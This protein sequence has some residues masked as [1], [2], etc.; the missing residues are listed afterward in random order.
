MSDTKLSE[1]IALSDA[2]AGEA[3]GW[4]V[5]SRKAVRR[6]LEAKRIAS[7]LSS[8]DQGQLLP[9]HDIRSAPVRESLDALFQR[10][11]DLLSRTE[12]YLPKAEAMMAIVSHRMKAS[13]TSEN[14]S[15]ANEICSAVVSEVLIPRLRK[16]IKETLTS[17]QDNYVDAAY[18]KA[19]EN[20]VD[21][22]K[23][24]NQGDKPQE[25]DEKVVDAVEKKED[26]P[27]QPMQDVNIKKVEKQS[28]HSL[29][30]EKAKYKYPKQTDDDL[31]VKFK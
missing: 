20:S 30:G 14:L 18:N 1:L 26:L 24:K 3:L 16:F 15:L 6:G 25:T 11:P 9:L 31:T 7:G 28:D 8:L 13:I 21:K 23:K 5:G 17:E 10:Y 12:G 2:K 22:E 19:A 29:K 27:D 4:P